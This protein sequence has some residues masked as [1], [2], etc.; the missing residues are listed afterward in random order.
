MKTGARTGRWY[1]AGRMMR[2]TAVREVEVDRIGEGLSGLD[3]YE[4]ALVILR[5]RG[6]VVGQSHVQV[7]EGR[8]GPGALRDAVAGAAWPAWLRVMAAEAPPADLPAASVVVCTRDRAHELAACLP[9]LQRMAEE[10]HDVIVVDNAS[11]DDATAKLVAGYPRV[12]YVREPRAGLDIA[13]N[14]GLREARGEVVAFTDDDARVDAGWLDAL[15]RNFEDPMVALVT[16]LTLPVELETEAQLWFE[17]TNGFGRGFLRREYDSSTLSPF[18]A[19][20]L[21][22]GVNMAVRRRALDDIGLFDETLDCGAET[23][24]GGDQE[25]FYRVL[26]RGFRAVYD[27][28]AIVWHRHRREWAA[29]RDCLHAYGVGVIAWWT[30][31]LLV[32][33]ELGLLALGPWWVLDYHVRHV[34][35]ALLRRPI[36]IPLDL[37]WAGLLGAFEGP[38]RYLQA[39]RRLRRSR[40]RTPVMSASAQGAKAS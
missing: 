27:P 6:A 40:E 29:L 13:R 26:A 15:R 17:E 22:A 21:G 11:R 25:F 24:S 9:G 39:R 12:R 18:G 19:G 37:A 33:R 4:L 7:D 36:R 35:G 23:R 10:G 30:R 8:V 31:A 32:E 1:R 34:M 38:F 28:A 3:G 16:G 14:R 20:R 2:R 5:L